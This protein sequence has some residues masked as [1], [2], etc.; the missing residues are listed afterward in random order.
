MDC[1]YCN[2][3]NH[4]ANDCMLRKRD[5]KKNNTKDEAYYVEKLEELCAKTKNLSLVAHGEK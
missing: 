2:G 1:H 4:L 3:P 5:E